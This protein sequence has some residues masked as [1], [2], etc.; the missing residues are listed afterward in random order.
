[1]YK[2]TWLLFLISLSALG[3]NDSTDFRLQG[4]AVINPGEI[5]VAIGKKHNRIKTSKYGYIYLTHN[6]VP[7]LEV[8]KIAR[9]TYTVTH[10]QIPNK[11]ILISKI[12]IK[13]NKIHFTSSI[14]NKESPLAPLE[15]RGQI[16]FSDK[17]NYKND[18]VEM[19]YKYVLPVI[20]DYLT[21]STEDHPNSCINQAMEACL[22][23]VTNKT[24]D[25]SLFLMG[26]SYAC[27]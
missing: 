19:I 5:E 1:M 17:E 8:E 24:I 26:C 18:Y 7:R 6:D 14:D 10:K 12:F 25:V 21:K 2:F 9:R 16:S 22:K 11:K 15:L 3:Q 20:H 4:K 23:K 27:D 13:N